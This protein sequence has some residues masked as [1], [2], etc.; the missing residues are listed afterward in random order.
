LLGPDPI[1]Y[2]SIAQDYAHGYWSEAINTYWSPLMSW[3]LVPLLWMHVPGLLAARLFSILSGIFLLFSIKILVRGFDLPPLL[4]TVTMYTAALIAAAFALTQLGPD[5]LVAAL[6]LLY[7]A[8]VFER[9][10]PRRPRAGIECGLLAVAAFL[11]KSYMLY[12]FLA[13]FTLMNAL[14]WFRDSN[15]RARVL[16]QFA[17]GILVFVIG[18]APWIWAMSAKAG[19]FTVG[20]TGA[21]NYRLVGPDTPGYPQYYGLIP[22]P[23]PHATSMWEDPSPAL[24]PPWSPL[25]SARNLHHQVRLI[26]ANFKDLAAIL[27]DTSVF[28]FAA[29]LGYVIWGIARGQAARYPWILVVLTIVLLPLGYLLVSL[30]DRYIWAALLLIFLAGAVVVGAVVQDLG[31]LPARIAIACYALSFAILPVREFIG[32]RNSGRSW[33]Q[34][35][36]AL[37]AKIPPHSRLAA[38]GDWNDSLAVA[39]YLH[40]PFYGSTGSTAAE[41]S[42]GSDLR[43][44]NATPPPEPPPDPAQIERSLRDHHISY[45]LAWPDCRV[46]P[47]SQMLGEPAGVPGQP[48]VKLFPVL[49]AAAQP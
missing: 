6:S 36:Q 22:P 3:L 39:Y 44:N 49:P 47:P 38:C 33:Y 12:F 32:R 45:Y 37:Q 21:W 19:A 26:A 18:C 48:G 23:G 43:L 15:V 7:F 27:M 20:T 28:S 40:V 25:S 42:V 30:R 2:I 34:I 41:D 17:T 46:F 31:R 11:S 4:Q 5:L 9:D 35:S 13:H 10:Y 16:R 1:S 24:L 29:V 8:I 14:H